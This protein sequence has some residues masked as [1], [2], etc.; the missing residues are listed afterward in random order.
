MGLVSIDF[1]SSVADESAYT[2]MQI[3]IDMFALEE[4]CKPEEIRIRRG[5]VELTPMGYDFLSVCADE[6]V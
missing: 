4:K 6:S 3:N 2:E 5:L 1:I